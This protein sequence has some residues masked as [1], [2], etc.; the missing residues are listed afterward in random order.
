MGG[1]FRKMGSFPLQAP[2]LSGQITY[3]PPHHGKYN[4]MGGYNFMGGL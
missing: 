3:S 4:I 1:F 2:Q